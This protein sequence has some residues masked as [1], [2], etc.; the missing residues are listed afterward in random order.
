MESNARA[1]NLI[2]FCKHISY[3]MIEDKVFIVD[4]RN[5]KFVHLNSSASLYLK[6]IFEKQ[7]HNLAV[8]EIAL[9]FKNIEKNIIIDD[10]NKFN[11][12]LFKNEIIMLW[13]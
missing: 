1:D 2:I 7:D 3:Q 13:K 12:F 10:F 8:E 11:E 4:E 5:E 9:V 6:K